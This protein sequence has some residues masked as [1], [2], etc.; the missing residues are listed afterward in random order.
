MDHLQPASGSRSPGADK[1]RQ[2]A[3]LEVPSQTRRVM[4]S[5]HPAFPVLRLFSMV[6]H[7]RLDPTIAV[8]SGT[9]PAALALEGHSTTVLL[10]MDTVLSIPVAVRKA[11]T[12]KHCQSLLG[13]RKPSWRFEY[14]RSWNDPVS[15]QLHLA[16]IRAGSAAK[17]APP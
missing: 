3:N 16:P 9:C 6:C 12:D 15:G 5:K 2:S 4:S 8:H 7:G 13:Q 1:F 17:I 10:W 11:G 14:H